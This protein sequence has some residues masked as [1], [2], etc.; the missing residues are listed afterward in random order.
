MSVWTLQPG[1]LFW[2]CAVID[3]GSDSGQIQLTINIKVYNFAIKL[4]SVFR[5]FGASGFV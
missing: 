2:R 1:G 4:C 3:R 5:R